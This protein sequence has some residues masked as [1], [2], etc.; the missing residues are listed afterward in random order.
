MSTINS[1]VL[2]I[3]CLGLALSATQVLAGA[4]SGPDDSIRPAPV[5][6]D[7]KK[8]DGSRPGGEKGGKSES[9]SPKGA[10]SDEPEKSRP[11]LVNPCRGNPQPKWCEE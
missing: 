9:L 2:M 6:D 4:G 8:D 7:D 3:G 5:T 11:A 1:K 10:N